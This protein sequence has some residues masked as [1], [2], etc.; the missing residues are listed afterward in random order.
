MFHAPVPRFKFACLVCQ[1]LV[2]LTL[3]I[4][5]SPLL[6]QDVSTFARSDST[7][8]EA[9]HALFD[10]TTPAGG[11]FPSNRFTTPDRTHNTGRRVNMP[12]PDCT[13]RPSD[14]EDREVI[15]TLDGFNLQPRLS[16][17]FDGPIDVSTVT[18]RTVFLISMG[19]TLTGGDRG[20]Q[21]GVLGTKR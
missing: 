2:A 18:S 10:L 3:F 11:P 19:S 21:V 1:A 5:A 13:V 20:G 9:V 4:L 12:L 14:C 6:A 17:P 15:N 8:A 7:S 16:V